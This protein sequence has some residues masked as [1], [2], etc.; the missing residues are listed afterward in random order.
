MLLQLRLLS[1]IRPYQQ[2]YSHK[3]QWNAEPLSH[4][5]FH[6]LLESHLIFLHIFD[7]EPEEKDAYQEESEDKAWPL[8]APVLPIDAEEKEECC[9]ISEAS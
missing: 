4:I 1:G 7:K 3:Y 6:S 2:P 8:F 9:Q 5:Q